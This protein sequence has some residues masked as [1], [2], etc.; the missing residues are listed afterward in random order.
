VLDLVHSEILAG[1]GKLVHRKDLADIRLFLRVRTSEVL[2][3]SFHRI[4]GITLEVLMAKHYIRAMVCVL[5]RPETNRPRFG[6]PLG[7]LVFLFLNVFHGFSQELVEQRFE[8]LQK[9]NSLEQVLY[10]DI[11]VELSQAGYSTSLRADGA[12]YVLKTVYLRRDALVDLTLSLYRSGDLLHALATVESHVSIDDSLDRQT[13]DA[14][15]QLLGRLRNPSANR[16]DSRI[17]GVFPTSVARTAPPTVRT[18]PQAVAADFPEPPALKSAPSFFWPP[19][20]LQAGLAGTAFFGGLSDI[21]HYG[22]GGSLGMVLAWPTDSGHWLTGMRVS[23]RRVFTDTGVTGGQL[24]FSGVS[25]VLGADSAQL[26]PFR[27]SWTVALGAM[28]IS[29]V[30]SSTRNKTVPWIDAGADL[31]IPLAPGLW[32]GGEVRFLTAFENTLI[33]GVTPGLLITKDF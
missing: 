4:L 2:C 13:G 28:V 11:G 22:A 24:Y 15:R 10:Y 16:P 27:T 17:E 12:G 19:V 26:R 1:K 31:A 33:L 8:S 5:P 23:G 3:G 6:C 21:A 14:V 25:A 9:D 30:G 32:A 7:F 20:R 18:V 29:V